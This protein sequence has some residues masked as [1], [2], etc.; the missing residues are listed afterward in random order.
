MTYL[1]QSWTNGVTDV[2]E[3]HMDHIEDGLVA[4]DQGLATIQLTPGPA[5]PQGPTG[6]QGPKGDTGAQGAAGAQGTAGAAGAA[7]PQGPQGVQG[8][9]GDPGVQGATGPAGA[10]G[11]QGPQGPQGP[12]GADGAPGA[13]GAAGAAGATGPAGP[14]GLPVTSIS[15]LWLPL[16]PYASLG[17]QVYNAGQLRVSRVVLPMAIK[18]VQ[19]DITAGVASTLRVCVFADTGTGPGAL[20]YQS[21]D[22]SGAAIA[23][24]TAALGPVP[25]GTYWI[26]VQNVG[27]SGAPT[28]RS[29]NGLNPFLTGVDVPGANALPNAWS[30]AGQGVAI[31]NPFPMAG[32]LRAGNTPAIFLQAS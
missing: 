7:G 28:I 8:V 23:A 27:A 16:W 13:A 1:R 12:A 20:L 4:L 3:A 11:S 22:I 31:P 10:N 30:N 19:L 14:A 29:I 15:N 2:D 21:A 9:K 18:A 32:V 17:T 25:A 26:G 6:A 5:G 24:P